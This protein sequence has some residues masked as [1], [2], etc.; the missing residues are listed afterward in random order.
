[1]AVFRVLLAA[2]AAGS[3]FSQ[4]DRPSSLRG[5]SALSETNSSVAPL[6]NASATMQEE[7]YDTMA[8]KLNVSL[9]DFY[10]TQGF[11]PRLFCKTKGREGQNCISG[12]AYEYCSAHRPLKAL[13]RDCWAKRGMYSRCHE[14]G[15]GLTHGW[16]DDPFC[17]QQ[18]GGR[19]LF[20]RGSA[21]V[22]C[23]STGPST[24]ATPRVVQT[25]SDQTSNVNNCEIKQHFSCS[26]NW[27]GAQCV[28]SGTTYS[29][30]GCGWQGYR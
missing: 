21:V 24:G 23:S 5:G 20:C 8:M 26:E 28:Y 14:G 27:G 10:A 13:S 30:D 17:R 2:T 7:I 29:G 1:M 4:S 12:R 9:G 11:D 25:C 15:I 22:S 16:C 6:G 18:G 3:A 19:H